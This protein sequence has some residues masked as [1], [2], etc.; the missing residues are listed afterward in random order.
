M[1]LMG[2]GK[3]RARDR[4]VTCDAP[5]VAITVPV[6]QDCSETDPL[7]FPS[8]QS[9]L[10]N[11]ARCGKC[12]SIALM[13]LGD[14]NRKAALERKAELR[15]QLSSLE[16]FVSDVPESDCYF[17]NNMEMLFAAEELLLRCSM[18]GI[19]MEATPTFVKGQPNR[20]ISL[21]QIAGLVPAQ[22]ADLPWSQRTPIDKEYVVLLDMS[23]LTSSA[24][25]CRKVFSVLSDLFRNE[26]ILKI[27]LGLRE[28][29]RNLISSYPDYKHQIN[30]AQTM[31]DVS[32]LHNGINKHAMK[33]KLSLQRLTMMYLQRNLLKPKRITMGNWDRRPLTGAQ[34]EYAVCDALVLLR[35]IDVMMFP[36][37]SSGGIQR[38]HVLTAARLVTKD[39][40]FDTLSSSI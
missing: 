3:K 1:N 39:V 30:T 25:C 12:H 24:A 14:A 38:A 2:K 16:I 40:V 15:D 29:I 11:S 6:C 34:I 19:D 28:D 36:N 37:L 32:D 35:L 18:V 31:L 26:A 10:G 23:V 27:G 17:V 13:R 9:R 4:A 20:P 7:K 22:K 21:I 33:D 8:K 5:L